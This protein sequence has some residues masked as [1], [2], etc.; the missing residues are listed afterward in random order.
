MFVQTDN[1]DAWRNTAKLL[2][3]IHYDYHVLLD[4]ANHIADTDAAGKR[5]LMRGLVKDKVACAAIAMM[6]GPA[7]L[8]VIEVRMQDNATEEN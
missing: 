7:I 6:L 2:G 1:R 4:L 5:K 8:Q 3:E